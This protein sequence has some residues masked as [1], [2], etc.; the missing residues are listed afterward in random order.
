MADYDQSI[1]FGNFAGDVA[2][3]IS[4]IKKCICILG[5]NGFQTTFKI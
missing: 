2:V 5:P 3:T 4:N 1:I